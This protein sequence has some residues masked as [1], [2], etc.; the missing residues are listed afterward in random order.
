MPPDDDL[1]IMEL[2]HGHRQHCTCYD[3]GVYHCTW[4]L[5][6]ADFQY[7]WPLMTCP[8]GVFCD[9]QNHSSP[10]IHQQ[11]QQLQQQQ[12]Q[13]QK[14]QPKN[15]T[16]VEHPLPSAVY[17]QS[18]TPIVF[19]NSTLSEIVQH[20]NQ[21][22]TLSEIVQL[23]NQDFWCRNYA[24]N[25][26]FYMT[27]ALSEI[28]LSASNAQ[29]SYMATGGSGTVCSSHCHLHPPLPHNKLLVSYKHKWTYNNSKLEPTVELF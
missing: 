29:I 17:H 25:I 21:D 14:Q 15:E 11:K 27:F 19:C 3:S 23:Q 2:L 20:Q 28:A 24:S 8:N 1:Y 12:Q 6:Q 10:T 16:L 18:P 4:P 13:Q 26:Q 7:D 9:K 22:L 5:L